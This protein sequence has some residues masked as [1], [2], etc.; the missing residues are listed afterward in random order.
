MLELI[1]AH[2]HFFDLDKGDYRWLKA[3]NP[4]FWPDKPLIAKNWGET[5][6]TLPSE[7]TLT[8]Y[9]H[10]EAGFDNVRLWREIEWLE[11][12]NKLPFRSIACVDLTKT[13]SQFTQ[14]L[15]KLRQYPTVVGTRHILDDEAC[16][17]LGLWNVQQNL[18][19]LAEHDLIFELQMPFINTEAVK[20]LDSL[21]TS[22][23]SLTV[24]INHAGFPPNTNDSLYPAWATNLRL[25]A[26]HP[27]VAI[28]CSGWEM[29]D[30]RYQSNWVLT[31]VEE[32]I[33]N[34][35]LDRVMLASNFPLCLFSQS[36]SKYWQSFNNLPDKT[37]KALL[38]HNAY[39]WYKF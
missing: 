2:L 6:L 10:I 38:S 32:C 11:T 20:Q 23:P 27:K 36:Y 28:K 26:K 25:I 39:K 5:D 30:R 18:K 17:L 3:E 31:V 24:I 35:G 33:S 34:F 21:L 1:D 8:G 9:V 14:D 22:I 19:Q 12:Y 16:E 13:T 4:P 7:L 29:G 37:K 15:N